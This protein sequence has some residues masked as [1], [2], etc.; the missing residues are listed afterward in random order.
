MESTTLTLAGRLVIEPRPAVMSTWPGL[1]PMRQRPSTRAIRRSSDCQLM[2]LMPVMSPIDLPAFFPTTPR[3][4]A[5]PPSRVIGAGTTQILIGVNV[6]DNGHVEE[7]LRVDAVELGRD[8]RVTGMQAD[9]AAVAR[10][11]QGA[12]GR[13]GGEQ[14]RSLRDQPGGAVAVAGLDA[15]VVELGSH[16][17]L[18]RRAL[19]ADDHHLGRRGARRRDAGLSDDRP[20][21]IGF[22]RL[23]GGGAVRCRKPG[24]Q[25]QQYT[26]ACPSTGHGLSPSKTE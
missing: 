12:G 22:F 20:A 18:D 9:Q 19:V 26:E 10:C 25:A 24:C 17:K 3:R 16:G 13:L 8:R 5:S 2:L 23:L 4:T 14:H 7:F 6:L 15:E 1:P 21:G 11:Q